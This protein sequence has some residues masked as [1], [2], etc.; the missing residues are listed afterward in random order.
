MEKFKESVSQTRGLPHLVSVIMPTY[1]G[2]N[3]AHLR[4]A[5]DSILI[6]DYFQLEL[7]LVVDG[8]VT[9]ERALVLREISADERVHLLNLATNCGPAH[10][11]NVGIAH[12]SGD[13]I[14]IM[15][16]DDI[17]KPDRISHQL[18]AIERLSVDVI[19]SDLEIINEDGH[20]IGGRTLP[21]THEA[22]RV[23]APFRCPLHNGSLF[24]K[25]SVLKA[26][27]YNI[28]FRVSEDYELWLRLILSGYRLANTQ[29]RCVA[30]RQ[31]PLAVA[32]RTGINYAVSDFKIKVQ[33][34]ALVPFSRKP[35]VLAVALGAMIA[36]VL[37]M[38][39]F[40]RLYA[41]RE[42]MF[43]VLRHDPLCEND[44]TR[45]IHG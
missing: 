25:A 41:C 9:P 42:R 2:D 35:L 20:L 13:Y 23:S 31:S 18:R 32:K 21:S 27:P 28:A 33:A 15:D 19:S 16:A 11:R 17:A 30:Y 4:L 44:P 5:V 6:Q 36:R 37:P 29:Y 39:I 12:A 38:P 24:A 3:E 14:A 10:A 1:G 40:R 26:N 8:P 34:L 7:I 22:I 43:S 45:S